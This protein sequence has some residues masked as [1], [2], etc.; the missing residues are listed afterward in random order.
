[1]PL[2]K[3]D[4]L[5]DVGDNPSLTELRSALADWKTTG[6]PER[7][8]KER[9][10]ATNHAEKWF[11][12]V[13]HLLEPDQH[14]KIGNILSQ[15]KR[16]LITAQDVNEQMGYIAGPIWAPFDP[17]DVKMTIPNHLGEQFK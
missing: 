14:T 7:L 8:S 4:Q 6:Q 11:H 2:E 17:A 15:G 3:P 1:M 13:K 5:A 10:D 12:G 16:G 9:V